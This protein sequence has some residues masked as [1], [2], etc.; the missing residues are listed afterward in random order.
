[1]VKVVMKFI[2]NSHSLF[3]LLLALAF[4]F[5]AFGYLDAGSGSYIIQILIASFLGIV[6]T[7]K[8]VWGKVLNKLGSLFKKKR[9]DT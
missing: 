8:S 2:Y 6:F 1:M 5:C 4:P 7:F 3:V 9:Q